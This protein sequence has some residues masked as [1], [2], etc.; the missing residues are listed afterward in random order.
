MAMHELNAVEVD[1]VSGGL[2]AGIGEYQC[3]AD[4]G[5]K[6]SVVFILEDDAQN[7]PDH[8]DAHRSTAYVAGGFVKRGFV[9]H[10]MYS[11]SSMLRTI[12]L[13]LGMKP[14]SQYDAAARPMYRCFSKQANTTAFQAVEPLTDIN[15]KNVAVNRNSIRSQKLNLAQPDAINDLEFSEIVWQTVRGLNSKMPSPK[16]SAFVRLGQ[17]D[18]DDEEDGDDDD[19]D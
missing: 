15:A 16:R 1:V 17:G 2:G 7:G 10:T 9:D 8:V 14:M 12:E 5:R 3:G 13:I 18:D 4:Q 19:D 6:E 11:T